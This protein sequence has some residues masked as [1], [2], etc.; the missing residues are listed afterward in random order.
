MPGEDGGQSVSYGTRNEIV[1]TSGQQ[2]VAPGPNV[3][4]G[5]FCKQCIGT[6]PHSFTYCVWLL[7][8]CR[9]RV[10]GLRQRTM[11]T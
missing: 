7:S 9:D 8:S 1:G 10:K 3:P 11:Q 6:Q 4:R 2:T 5:L